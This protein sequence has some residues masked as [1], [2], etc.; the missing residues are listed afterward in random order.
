MAL[1]PNDLKQIVLPAN[2][3]AT[4]LNNLS[5]RDGTT[6]AAIL[7]DINAGLTLVNG[8]NRGG[9]LAGLYS[10]TT[11]AT[12]E[13][14]MGSTNGFEVHTE[15]GIPDVK[16]GVSR[17]HMIPLTKY[18]RMLG[19]TWDFLREAR[20]TQLDADVASAIQDARDLHEKEALTRFFKM[21]SVAVGAA[22]N[23]LPFANG[24]VTDTAWVP[25]PYGGNTFLSSHDHYFRTTD[26]DAGRLASIATMAE[27]LYHHGHMAPYDLIIPSADA[28]TWAD[29][30]GFIGG[31]RP[32]IA[33]GSNTSVANVDQMYMGVFNS[34]YG[35]VRV[36]STPRL[37]TD[38]SGMYK[39]YGVNDARNPLARRVDPVYF[40]GDVVLMA[41]TEVREFPI[42]KAMLFVAFGFGVKD[43]TNGAATYYA[44]AGDYTTPTIS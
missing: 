5:L 21:E 8:A 44:G 15:Y 2:W 29:L 36:Y 17:G 4:I 40:G 27:T 23:S 35:T 42:E 24:G 18:D 14:A 16:R 19:W 3:D 25:P 20:Q 39:R 28:G 1:G 43:R 11:D 34:D 26:D 37:P 32:D 31:A 41:T 6:F 38:Y 30:T 13:Y 9:Y 12:I 33:F 10:D 22:G 7:A